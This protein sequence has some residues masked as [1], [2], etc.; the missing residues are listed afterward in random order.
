MNQNKKYKVKFLDKNKI[1]WKID[2]TL[3]NGVLSITGEGN[4]CSGQVL[5]EIVPKNKPQE[6]LINIWKEYHLN[7]LHAGT[8]LQEKVLL[9][10]RDKSYKRVLK[11]LA[12][13][14]KNG[15]K[16]SLNSQKLMLKYIDYDE[17]EELRK[18]C[19][20]YDG[21]YRYGTS[22]LK[23]ELPDNFENDLIDL[24]FDI[25][26]IEQEE[27]SSI[28]V[29]DALFEDNS[30]ELLSKDEEILALAI[31]LELTVNEIDDIEKLDYGYNNCL[32]KVHGREYY[33]GTK[34]DMT[35]AVMEYIEYSLWTFN[36][37]FLSNYGSFKALS[38][39]AVKSICK[40]LEDECEGAN[41]VFLELVDWD[42][43]KEEITNDAIREDGYG[44][45]LNRYDGTY[46]EIEFNE[47]TFIICRGN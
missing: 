34:E 35:N 27:R 44:N 29:K 33:C 24:I 8:E 7:N 26:V 19:L 4:G 36:S 13:F 15:N 32:Y 21:D 10:C 11:Y 18:N 46:E 5:D 47:K 38:F 39:G 40:V 30:D 28:L 2:I 23:R 31:Y 14:D 43:N 12:L 22:W 9:N 20:I 6:K 17:F 37:S 41:D 42:N 45:F 1:N 3:E 16:L 25:E